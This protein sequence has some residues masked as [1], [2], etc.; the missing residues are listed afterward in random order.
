M[1]YLISHLLSQMVIEDKALGYL[2]RSDVRIYK[3]WDALLLSNLFI[4]IL[5]SVLIF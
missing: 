1:D 4:T 2:L 5:E 3:V